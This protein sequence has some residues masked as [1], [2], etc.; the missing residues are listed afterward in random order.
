MPTVTFHQKK[1]KQTTGCQKNRSKF[2]KNQFSHT[3][4]RIRKNYTMSK[5]ITNYKK[6]FDDVIQLIEKTQIKAYKSLTEHQLSLNFEIGRTIV[7][8][9]EKQGWGKSVVDDLSKDINKVIDGI[10]GYSPQNLWR[11]RSFYLAYKDF[12]ELLNLALQ[13]P[14][15][16]NLLIISKIST[17]EE[18]GYYLDTTRKLGWSRAVLLNQIKANAFAHHKTN[19]KLHNFK[20]ALPVHLSEQA[21]EA[22]KSE[23]NLDFLGIT[24]PISE[25]ELENRLIENVRD[26]LME[27]GFGFCFIGNQYRIKLGKKE[28]FLD[29]LFYHRILKCLV[30][31]EL[32]VVGFEPEFAGKMNF[33]LEV[34]DD[35]I[36]EENDNP[37]IGI[38]LCPEKDDIEVEYA[39]RASNKP[40]GVSEYKLTQELPEKLRG[41]IPTKEEIIQSLKKV[42]R[43]DENKKEEKRK[44]KK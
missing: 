12:P 2:V 27:L 25:R 11:M 36:K 29:L 9:Q 17:E 37:S 1:K 23:Y 21:T 4:E 22:L 35:T 18:R 10:K 24:D 13:I 31:V 39:L 3:C 32:K 40:I 44:A 20:K 8:S 30:A 5:E 19:P 43:L 26:L 6:L 41:K 14:W 15:S 38:I 34:L 7:E 28:Y 33:Y 16:Q 42:K